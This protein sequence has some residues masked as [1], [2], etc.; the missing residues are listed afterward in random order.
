MLNKCPMYSQETNIFLFK[1][2]LKKNIPKT[3]S[4]VKQ[5]RKI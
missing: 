1:S 5:K 2:T 3:K 4:K